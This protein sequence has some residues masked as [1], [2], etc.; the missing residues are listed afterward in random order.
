VQRIAH[1]L[2]GLGYEPKRRN[3][4]LKE[5]AVN[6]LH[7]AVSIVLLT[8][9]LASGRAAAEGVAGTWELS[10]VTGGTLESIAAIVKLD[11]KDGKAAGEM[12]APSPRLPSLTLK[13]VAR[14]GDLVR[15]VFKNGTLDLSFE[16]KVPARPGKRILASLA[17]GSTVYP[18]FLTAT[19]KTELDQKDL[20]RT[21]ACPP[22]AQ[23]RALSQ[24]SAQLRFRAQSAKDPEE[25]KDLLK[26]AAEAE[27]AARAQAPDLYREVL[28]KH[29]DS[30]A[31]FDA[32]LSLVRG[33]LVGDAKPEEVK[34]WASIAAKAAE[35]YGPRFHGEIAAQLATT[36]VNQ[37]GMEQ[38][39]VAMARDARKT[40]GADASAT[41]RSRVLGVLARAL[42][43]AGADGEA[44][45]IDAELAKLED[46][47]DREYHAA[48]P[49]FKGTP[50]AGR[51]GKSDR[52]VFLE[53]FT[54]ATCPPCVAADLAFDVLMKTYEPRELVLV[55]YHMHIPGPDP[56]TNPDTEE[57][58][59][60]YTKAFP[61]QVRGVPSSLFNGKPAGSGGGPLAFAQKKYDA[62][63]E[64]IDP[65][66]EGPAGAKLNVQASRKGDRIDIHVEVAELAEP[67]THKK[68]RILVAEETIRY[69]GSNKIRFHHNVVRAFPGGVGGA[70]LTNRA[71]K[72]TASLDLAEL[73]GQLTKY[74]D[75]YEAENR[76]F[77]NPARPLDF[78]NLR[79]IA[80]VQD[81]ETQEI[82]QAVQADLK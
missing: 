58:W 9:A 54:G 10:Y 50:F 42:R 32:A 78:N 61:M 11:D 69:L 3:P 1:A 41:D 5:F 79:V 56:L 15:I 81:D 60:Y 23:A 59:K 14:D 70:A 6:R 27:K 77:A 68:L 28:A 67:A 19:E 40:L 47:L 44:K 31:L 49:G 65:L 52:A 4:L 55:Q 38:L 7:A 30:P 33:A 72:H 80:F 71:S 36:L 57:R 29:Q 37:Q 73:R 43:K 24:K 75:N 46:E 21:L 76:P 12:I 16:A 63:R 74:L 66:L 48:M 82:V 53:L 62:Y 17:A 2:F 8:T 25:K 39:A 26:E 13:S 18:A 51:K 45:V 22:M 35:A 64:V 20:S 34:S